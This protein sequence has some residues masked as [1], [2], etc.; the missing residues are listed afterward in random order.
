MNLSQT[1]AQ[2][3]RP[4]LDM[5]KYELVDELRRIN[6]TYDSFDELP[7]GDKNLIKTGAEQSGVDF[8]GR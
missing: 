8:G 7:L 2:I 5:Q 4:L 1:L 3:V 6:N